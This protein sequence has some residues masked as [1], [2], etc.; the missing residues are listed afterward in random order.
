VFVEHRATAI[1]VDVLVRLRALI[2][3]DEEAPRA[4]GCAPAGDPYTVPTLA[5]AAVLAS[6]GFEATNLGPETPMWSFDL[7]LEAVGPK[8]AWISA[9]TAPGSDAVLATLEA[10]ARMA[11]A[12]GASLVVGGRAFEDRGHSVP[13]GVVHCRTI[14]ELAAFARGLQTA[15]GEL[16]ASRGSE[17]HS[18]EK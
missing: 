7:A 8:I 6:E 15:A 1:V 18:T 11:G 12:V 2:A 4:V 14:G 16:N 3:I 9:S 5:V 17:V 13:S 10:T